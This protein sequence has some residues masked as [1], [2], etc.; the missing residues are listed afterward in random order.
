[1]I[2]ISYIILGGV[3]FLITIISH[4]WTGKYYKNQKFKIFL[5]LVSTIAS[6]LFTSAVIIQIS[7]Y[8]TQR[9]N[10]EIEH[11]NSLSKIYLDDTLDFFMKYPEMNYYYEDLMGIKP[12]DNNTKR[13]LILENQISMLI[14]SRLAKFA[15]FT[16]QK[17]TEVSAKIENWLGH[18]TKTFMKSKTLRHYWINEYKPKLSGPAARQY[19]KDNFNL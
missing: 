11:Y 16:Q 1:M 3:V 19:M 8:N 5:T 4:F 10:E 13:N 14:F 7:A 12:I 17:D 18:I 2:Q 6:L 15:V 9:S